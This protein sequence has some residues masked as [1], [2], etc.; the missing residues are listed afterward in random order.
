MSADYTNRDDLVKGHSQTDGNPGENQNSRPGGNPAENRHSQS[1]SNPAENRDSQPGS[2]P[3][4]NRHSRSGSTSS[5]ESL[6]QEGERIDDLQRAGLRIIQDP[7]LFCFG[8]DA[9]L[10]SAFVQIKKARRGLDLGT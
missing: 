8:M 5:Y 6:L 9:V 4:E 3:A 2:N 7:S 10:L 1:D